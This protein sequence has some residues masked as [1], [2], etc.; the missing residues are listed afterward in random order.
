MR[1][2]ALW[3]A[4]VASLPGC[5]SSSP[6]PPAAPRPATPAVSATP[7]ARP[8]NVTPP[9][10][11]TEKT[12][13]T[14]ADL[15]LRPRASIG[16]CTKHKARVQGYDWVTCNVTLDELA[17]T[18]G[19]VL[20]ECQFGLST[21][22]KLAEMGMGVAF[23]T[24]V[25]QPVFQTISCLGP[26]LMAVYFVADDRMPALRGSLLGAAKT[27][28]AS[29]HDE[30][31]LEAKFES[32]YGR[33]VANAQLAAALGKEPGVVTSSSTVRFCSPTG[34]TCHEA[35]AWI[36]RYTYEKRDPG[37]GFFDGVE[38]ESRKP[39]MMRLLDIDTLKAV[40]SVLSRLEET[41]GAQAKARALDQVR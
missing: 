12:I 17:G 26:D 30:P 11:P 35:A 8:A 28:D 6:V 13:A 1:R 19:D 37:R 14:F 16:K 29:P 2:I 24:D 22:Q 10:Q 34:S 15:P 41:K 38:A 18:E 4:L 31:A 25:T 3:V 21:D 40:K 23:D 32:V 20:H 27:L 7:A 39:P 5:P 36:N 33:M 9:T